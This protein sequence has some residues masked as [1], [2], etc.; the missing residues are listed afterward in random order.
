MIG[1]V[2][3]DHHALHTFNTLYGTLQNCTY[4]VSQCSAPDTETFL[5]CEHSLQSKQMTRS[6]LLKYTLRAHSDTEYL[7]YMFSALKQSLT[8]KMFK[9]HLGIASSLRKNTGPTL[10]SC[11]PFFHTKHVS[12]GPSAHTACTQLIINHYTYM[13]FRD[14]RNC[15]KVHACNPVQ[16]VTDPSL[17]DP[18]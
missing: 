11:V 8:S 12:V 14:F 18:Q 15:S 9:N 10:D 13:H 17:G 4:M 16:C 3:P 5:I 1:Y 7:C 2:K 6:E